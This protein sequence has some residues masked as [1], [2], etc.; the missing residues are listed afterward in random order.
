MPDRHH[1]GA[2]PAVYRQAHQMREQLLG[3]G[4]NGEIDPVARHHLGDL[5]RRALMQVQTHFRIFGAKRANHL[6]QH[7]ARLGVRG[8]NRQR[9]A[10]RLAQ[11][12][13][14][15]ADVLHFT[16]DA[17]GARDD[18]LA[19][20]RGAGQRPAL[21][22]EQLKAQFLLE[23]FQLSADAGLGGM[24]LPGCGGN[25]QSTLMDRY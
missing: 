11:L 7:I 15:A 12:R 16:Q 1:H 21:A 13:R 2:V 25:V 9:A 20:R 19:G 22:L 4:R 3:A 14:S 24:Q 18:L 10:I 8:R 6:R 23:Q 17:G 5:L